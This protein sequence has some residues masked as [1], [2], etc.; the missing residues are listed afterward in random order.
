MHYAAADYFL[1]NG[2]DTFATYFSNI[3]FQ[4]LGA[5]GTYVTQKTDFCLAKSIPDVSIVLK[6]M[7]LTQI[8]MIIT[9]RWL[10][11]QSKHSLHVAS[12]IFRDDNTIITCHSEHITVL[13]ADIQNPLSLHNTFKIFLSVHNSIANDPM[14][15]VIW[16][17]MGTFLSLENMMQTAQYTILMA[18]KLSF[19]I[20]MRGKPWIVL[21]CIRTKGNIHH[22]KMG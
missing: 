14:F 4:I 15:R 21:Y 8:H 5:S 3:C 19:M 20:N 9:A 17:W 18:V 12:S 2:D 1:R 7:C 6:L 22:L 11:L 10:N 16:I 13:K